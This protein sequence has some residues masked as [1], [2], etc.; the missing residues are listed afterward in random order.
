[1]KYKATM[2]ADSV[3]PNGVRLSTMQFNIWKPMLAEFNTHGAVSVRNF[4]SSRARPWTKVKEDVLNDPHIPH[5]RKNNPG[6]QPAE[7]INRFDQK[8]AEFLWLYGRNAMVQLVEDMGK[9]DGMNIH[10]QWLNR[11]IEPWT[12]VEGLVTATDWDNFFNLR[13]ELNDLG[14]PMAQDEFYLM[15]CSMKDC[16]DQSDPKILKAGDWHLPYVD[17]Q[18]HGETLLGLGWDFAHNDFRWTNEEAL[19]LVSAG[20]CATVSYNNLGKGIEP[21]ADYARAT[22]QLLPNGHMSVFG[23]Q[24]RCMEGSFLTIDDKWKDTCRIP[25]SCIDST[26]NT[27]TENIYWGQ[28]RGW[29]QFRKTLPNEAVWIS[30]RKD[31]KP[32]MEF[33]RYGL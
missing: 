1:M 30:P 29:G 5:F 20:R 25:G 3:G 32:S 11:L 24:A 14:W 16:L 19:A 33:D 28:L 17:P 18:A 12:V 4:P 2:I 7:Y 21:K 10:K 31:V 27:G 13:T 23:H 22:E 8:D 9:K 26:L 6:M 15:A